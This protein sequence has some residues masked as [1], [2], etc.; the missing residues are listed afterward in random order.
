MFVRLLGQ[1]AYDDES[2]DRV[3]ELI[4]KFA[5]TEKSGENNNSVVS[6]LQHLFSL[7]LSGTHA[8]PARRQA[9][10]NRLLSSGN[11]RHLDIASELFRSAFE[12]SHWT[13]SGT[14][15]FG[16]RSRDCGWTPKT[17]KEKLDWYVGFIKLLEPILASKGDESR[18]WAKELLAKH[19]RGLWLYAGCFDILEE[20]VCRYANGGSWPEMWVSIKQTIYFGGKELLPGLRTRLE[21]LEQ[22]A[23]PSNPYSEIEAYVLTNTWDHIEFK[24][25][26]YKEKSKEVHEKIESLG[27]L[28]AA[29]PKYLKKLAPR[30]WVKDIDALWPF[31]KGL[32]KGSV[33]QSTLFEYL[34][35]LMQEQELDLVQPIL[36]S[37]FIHGV[38]AE[39]PSLARQLQERVL[40]VP[41]LKPHFIFLL[42]ATPIVPWGS[43]K[44]LEL[45]RTGEL[46]AWRFK[47]IRFGRLHETISDS[48]LF[49]ILSALNDLEGG[50]FSTLE[51]LSMR[52][53][54]DKG[55]DYMP[56]EMLR[57]VGR[58]AILKLFSMHRDEIRTNQMHGIDQVL[59]TCLSGSA[60]VKEIAEIVGMLCEGIENFSLSSFELENV[61]G[62]LAKN[63][64]ELVLNRVFVDSENE[65][66]LVYS[67]FRDRIDGHESPLNLAPADRVVKWCDGNQ[68]RIQKVA[69]AVSLYCSAD[70]E[71][72]PMDNPKQVI[73]SDHIK[74]LLEVAE[75]KVD[76]IETIFL[77]TWP[78]AWSGSL[79]EILEVRSKAFAEL[80]DHDSLEVRET[81]KVKLVKIENSAREKRKEEAEESNR[82][83]QR[84]E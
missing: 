18:A 7:Y 63:F 47:Q 56:S 80:L 13:S 41:E 39:K 65:E 17:L 3:C 54:V 14:F 38:H 37:G 28:A 68:D 58:D 26:N 72:E 81:A 57:A 20:I 33:D 73:L 70:K 11:S 49:E 83:E 84:F 78:S 9:F 31:G 71:T 44:L 46:E 82:Y 59:D 40:E 61:I 50:V 8:T 21:A 64:P 12:A 4:L 52:F 5:E 10:L 60:P 55:S 6:Q 19:F 66:R 32:A 76:M 24:G 34:I 67:L 1:L 35:G 30:L 77:R 75:S 79:A 74:S 53:F 48:D 36:F 45:A 42:G 62:V 43:K 16:A 22:L 69:T 25:G 23:A 51:I 2:F 29:E 27:G 15:G